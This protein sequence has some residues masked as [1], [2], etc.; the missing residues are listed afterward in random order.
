MAK[1]T[2]K[3]MMRDRI[4]PL[5]AIVGLE[6]MI[7]AKMTSG[8]VQTQRQIANPILSPNS[9]GCSLSIVRLLKSI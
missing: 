9:L 4:A 7:A 2:D 3:K 1:Q 6:K 8:R 5:H